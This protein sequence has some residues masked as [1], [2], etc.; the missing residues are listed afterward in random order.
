MGKHIF[1]GSRI[2]KKEGDPLNHKAFIFFI[3]RKMYDKIMNH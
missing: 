2:I 3:Q 1:L